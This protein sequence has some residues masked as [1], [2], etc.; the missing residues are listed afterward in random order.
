MSILPNNNYSQ[1]HPSL[2]QTPASDVQRFAAMEQAKVKDPN[3]FW[4]I[5]VVKRENNVH[6]ANNVNNKSSLSLDPPLSEKERED[7]VRKLKPIAQT[8]LT[9]AMPSLLYYFFISEENVRTLQKNIRYTVNKY[10]GYNVGDASV[11]ELRVLM[12]SIFLANA[13]TL[14]ERTTPSRVLFRHI[15]SQIGLLDDLVVNEAAPIIINGAEQHM[16]YLK[17]V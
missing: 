8:I 11:Q 3:A 15:R 14:D 13:K 10:S 7:I 6:S 4:T 9:N 17:R 5:P 1:S 2:F 16:S 12:E